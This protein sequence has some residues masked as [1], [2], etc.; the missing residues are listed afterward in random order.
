MQRPDEKL[1]L[2]WNDFRD[3][4][5]SAFRELRGDKDFT[6]VTLVCEDGEQVEAH[7][8]VLVSSSPF[9]RNLLAR[10]K[11]AH[12]LVFMR[13]VKSEDFVAI[14]DFLYYGE[15]NVCQKNLDAF[16][17]LAGELQLNGLQENRTDDTFDE[18]II[19]PTIKPKEKRKP[20]IA[21]AQNAE[22]PQ[23]VARNRS[24]QAYKTETAIWFDD[25]SDTTELADLEQHVKS[26]M[27]RSE[28]PA[29]GKVTGKGRKC[30]VCGKEGS[31]QTINVHIETNHIPGLALPCEICGK[32]LKS[33][34]MLRYH[35]LTYHK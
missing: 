27:E 21:P 20:K 24:D 9:F 29:P 28:N 10:V 15:A 13:G 19:E 18:A 1:C 34:N 26:M 35:K 3:N 7:K 22:S 30:K 2:Q 14:L 25:H 31:M 32:I 33:R 4:I 23:I 8:L 5:G 12:P 16:L 6:D 17:S 11:H